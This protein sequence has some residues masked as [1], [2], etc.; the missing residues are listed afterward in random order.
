MK[1]LDIL[2]HKRTKELNEEMEKNKELFDQVIDA[3]RRKNNYFINLSH[4]LRT[5]LN[6]LNSIEQLISN[7]CDSGKQIKN[8]Q[9][10]NYMNMMKNNT[11]R[12]MNLI[13][14][15]LDT[16]K[17]ENG[18]YIINKQEQDIVYIV[19]EAALSLKKSIESAGI[20]L[21]IDTDVEEKIINCDK[22][23]IEKCIINLVGNAV[24]FTPS[25]GKIIVNIEDIED[26]VK[27]IV[28]DTGMGIDE[29]YHN[30]IFD[31]FNQVVDEHSESKNGSGLGLTITKQIIDMHNGEITLESEKDKGCKFTIILPA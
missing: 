3:E 22:T 31:R 11:S 23:D 9:L 28:S 8:E 10:S 14:N 1:A 13:N 24:K 21:V 15:I 16:S 17:M 6:V 27:I 19:E 7:Y 12:L 2:V 4:E 18:K 26:G 29:E 30:S 20:E 5:P 25:G